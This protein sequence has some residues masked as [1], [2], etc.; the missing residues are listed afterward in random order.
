MNRVF[1]HLHLPAE[2]AIEFMAALSRFEY[3]FKSTKYAVGTDSR[4][5]A[6]WDRFANEIAVYKNLTTRALPM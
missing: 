2:L 5:N 3:A 4:V 6:A 1:Q